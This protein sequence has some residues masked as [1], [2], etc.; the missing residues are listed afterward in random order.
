MRETCFSHRRGSLAAFQATL[1]SKKERS[2]DTNGGQW[3][4]VLRC[5]RDR[6]MSPHSE[7]PT[8]RPPSRWGVPPPGL[9]ARPIQTSLTH[10]PRDTEPSAR[11]STFLPDMDEV[12]MHT[13][14]SR[15]KSCMH[16]VWSMCV[17]IT[18]HRIKVLRREVVHLFRLI[19][20][21]KVPLWN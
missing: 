13:A 14:D 3:H 9:H 21:S 8:P 17:L 16:N 12:C 15:S 19:L 20:P 11:S 4:S 10:K 18:W 6:P 2:R 7:N 1:I 5:C